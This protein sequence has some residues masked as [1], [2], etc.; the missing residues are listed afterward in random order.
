MRRMIAQRLEGSRFGVYLA[1]L[2][3]F[4]AM[5]GRPGRVKTG[6]SR[7]QP[8]VNLLPVTFDSFKPRP[9]SCK[10]LVYSREPPVTIFFGRRERLKQISRGHLGHAKA[11]P[12]QALGDRTSH[13][14]TTLFEDENEDDCDRAP[15]AC[16]SS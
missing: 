5:L 16:P 3:H 6:G 7:E 8:S 10:P 13:Q 11:A 14:P 15:F 4:V 2:A 12:L 1:A 9:E